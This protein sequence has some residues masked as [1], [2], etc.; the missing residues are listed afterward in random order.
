MEHDAELIETGN[1]YILH[2]RYGP[3]YRWELF[4]IGKHR[5]FNQYDSLGTLLVSKENDAVMARV[6]FDPFDFSLAVQKAFSWDAADCSIVQ[7]GATRRIKHT[8]QKSRMQK[9]L[10]E[11][12][13]APILREVTLPM[14]GQGRQS[15]FY[16][17][18]QEFGNLRFPTAMRKEIIDEDGKPKSKR[19]VEN[20]SIEEV[21]NEVWAAEV[22]KVAPQASVEQ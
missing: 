8:N 15:F 10:E 18:S 3:G 5:T 4:S 12:G 11:V 22:R 17:G 6:P 21:G 16:E 13:A 20:I 14:P 2:Q 19:L 9:T 1:D 7:D